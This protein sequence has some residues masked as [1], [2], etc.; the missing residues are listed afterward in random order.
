MAEVAGGLVPR[1][2]QQDCGG[3]YQ[4]AWK[5]F[6]ERL[7]G[8]GRKQWGKD[9]IRSLVLECMVDAGGR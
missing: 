9:H 1:I 4:K 6:L 3:M 2:G 5:L 8:D 7:A